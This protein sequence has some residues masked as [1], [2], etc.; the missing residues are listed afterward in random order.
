M[1]QETQMQV[2]IKGWV[3]LDTISVTAQDE[4]RFVF[5]GGPRSTDFGSYIPLV[6]A[7][8]NA[9][10]PAFDTRALQV[11]ALR[12]RAKTVQAEAQAKLTQIEAQIGKLLAL[13]AA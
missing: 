9:D 3:Y 6:E 7:E 5:F 12:Q 13:E 10:V 11:A 1:R 4:P 8:V 2:T